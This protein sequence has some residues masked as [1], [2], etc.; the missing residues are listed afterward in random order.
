M[1]VRNYTYISGAEVK[2]AKFGLLTSETLVTPEGKESDWTSGV[3][4]ESL[5]CSVDSRV[6][7]ICDP[8]HVSDV[9]T[10]G[11]RYSQAVPFFIETEF[12]CSTFGF[13]KNDYFEKAIRGLEL[14]QGKDIEREFWTGALAKQDTGIPANPNR[15]L[16]SMSAQAVA[17]SGTPLRP[18]PGL[19]LLEKALGDCGCGT[20]GYIHATRDVASS[21]RKYVKPDG[22]QLI[23]NLGTVL[24]AGTGYTG[25]GPNGA[26]PTGSLRW[27]Y[28]TGQPSVGLGKVE[29]VPNTRSE[30]INTAVNTVNVKAQRPA[31]ATWDGCCHYAVL[32][33]LSLE[34]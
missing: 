4:I 21:L 1:V 31:F 19:A 2:P 13:G 9:S 3:T 24:V 20:Q 16:A 32:V 15:Y 30:A 14:C 8:S 11:I 33:D 6:I 7:E 17:A 29:P 23:T 34:Y 27:M 10:A 28:A 12:E 26:A 5:T 25:S 22:D 18:A